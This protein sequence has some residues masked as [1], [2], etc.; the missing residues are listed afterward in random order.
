MAYQSSN[1]MFRSLTD[2]EE[3]EFRAYARKT[4][5]PKPD[6]SLYHPVGW[7]LYHPVC[8]EEWRKRGLR[9][10]TDESAYA[11]ENGFRGEST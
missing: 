10:T 8:R 9:P 1:F 7:S 6:W 3:E 4:D 5:P 2:A 11:P